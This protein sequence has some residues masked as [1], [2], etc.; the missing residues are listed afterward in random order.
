MCG[1]FITLAI[2][3]ITDLLQHL[4][5]FILRMRSKKKKKKERRKF[6]TT[7]IESW[8]EKKIIYLFPFEHLCWSFVSCVWKFYGNYYILVGY[9]V[10]L[11]YAWCLRWTIIKNKTE[12]KTKKIQCQWS[13]SQFQWKKN[14]LIIDMIV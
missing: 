4:S 7:P 1:Q 10:C 12:T 13:Q 2:D 5:T 14:Y 6:Y 11:Q 8:C 9:I 3:V